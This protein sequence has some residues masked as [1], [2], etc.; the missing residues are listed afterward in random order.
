MG[1]PTYE[2]DADRKRE[3]AVAVVVAEHFNFIPKKCP[4]S[5]P[6]DY[7]LVH[8]R[9]IQVWLEVKC[10]SHAKGDY[11]TYMLSA[12]K[13]SAG[14]RLAQAT[15]RQ[16]MLAV[17]WKDCLGILHLPAECDPRWGGRNDRGD[18]QDMEPTVHFRHELFKVIA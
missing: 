12:Q 5:Y 9:D 15:G 6:I 8:G 7:V 14:L 11:D 18:W 2:T 4:N 16:F 10:R 13:Y 1:R 3:S 17:K